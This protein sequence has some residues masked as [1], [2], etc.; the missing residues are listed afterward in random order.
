MR[1]T[2]HERTPGIGRL[3]REDPFELLDRTQRLV[4]DCWRDGGGFGLLLTGDAWLADELFRALL[5]HADLAFGYAEAVDAETMSTATR[6]RIL[7][8]AWAVTDL[9]PALLRACT[10]IL[11][12]DTTEAPDR[13]GGVTLSRHLGREADPLADVVRMLATH[14]IAD[15][16]LDVSTARLAIALSSRCPDIL[17]VCRR[18]VAAPRGATH[19]PPME[20]GASPGTE[21]SDEDDPDRSDDLD[22][23]TDAPAVGETGADEGD[24]GVSEASSPTADPGSTPDAPGEKE[25]EPSSSDPPPTTE[26]GSVDQHLLDPFEL[27]GDEAATPP[28]GSDDART[29]VLSARTPSEGERP[30]PSDGTPPTDTAV[31]DGVP[32]TPSG[33]LEATADHRQPADAAT[34]ELD[35]SLRSAMDA[36]LA[37][38]REQARSTAHHPGRRGGSSVSSTHGTPTRDVPLERAQG[39]LA[40]LATLRRAAFRRAESAAHGEDDR[41]IRREDLRGALRNRRGGTHTVVIV[42]GSSSMGVVGTGLA[43]RAADVALAR[44]AGER[45]SVSVILAA[46]TAAALL[47]PCTTSATRIRSAIGGVVPDG[48]TPLAAAALLAAE[49]CADRPRSRSQVLVLSDGRATVASDGRTDPDVV[50]SDLTSALR[51]LGTVAG[52]V[53]LVVTGSTRFPPLARDLQPFVAGGV[54]VAQNV[55]QP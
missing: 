6:P 48:G 1:P 3:L 25:P 36:A 41:P 39:R 55:V 47:L 51:H 9:H 8:R 54:I 40:V 5:P 46:G 28:P 11:D 38:R 43:R 15:H 45:G 35:P 16:G 18:F 17:A 33:T 27:N 44:I 34:G 32:N 26:D 53:I 31:S 50:R 29:D 19:R 49:L 4:I 7:A 12:L 2:H 37:L 21:P 24:E 42:D 20:D 14:G 10:V 22:L 52:R 13:S 23:D 30:A